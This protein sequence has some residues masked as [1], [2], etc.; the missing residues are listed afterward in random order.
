MSNMRT[1]S[2]ESRFSGSIP[3]NDQQLLIRMSRVELDSLMSSLEV[4]FAKFAQCV[5][6]P[7]W[8]LSMQGTDVPGMHYNIAGKGRMIVGDHPPIDLLPHTLVILPPNQPFSI[9][10]PSEG[11]DTSVMRTVEAASL[12]ITPG[13]VRR[14]IAG[15]DGPGVNLICGYFR[16]SYGPS[17]DLF[18]S[19]TAPI[20]ERFDASD[21]LDT[22]LTAAVDELVAQQVGMGA[23]TTGLLK[24]VLIKFLRRSMTSMNQW[25]ERFSMLSDPQIARAFAD[26]S[27]RP[28]AR[29]SVQSLS[30]KVGLSRS[31]FMSRFTAVF[32]DSPMAILRKLR[33]RHAANLLRFNNISIEQVAHGAGYAS[34]SSFFRAFKKIYGCDPTE[35]RL[36]A[37][38]LLQK[39]AAAVKDIS[40]Q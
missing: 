10:V 3:V 31:V 18:T 30:S 22:S 12:K 40:P 39:Q 5:V 15:I 17:L 24:Q 33:M 6:S 21:R 38:R 25:V 8:R 37:M 20:V 19:I 35:H 4:N 16:A 28:G 26:M 2:S 9:E 7:G 36:N 23:M 13:E 27:A 29:H 34:R 11:R 1:V 32:S 14:F